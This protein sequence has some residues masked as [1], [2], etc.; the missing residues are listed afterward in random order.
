M[1]NKFYQISFVHCINTR[2][3]C[4]L[5]QVSGQIVEPDKSVWGD[6]M[7]VASVSV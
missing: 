7:P 2:I 6:N 1:S 3:L 5:Q 4:E